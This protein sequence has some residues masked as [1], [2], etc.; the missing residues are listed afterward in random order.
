MVRQVNSYIDWK[1]NTLQWR[2]GTR[3]IT[4]K[5]VQDPQ[6]PIMASSMFEQG[7]SVEQISAQRMR[8]IAK[9]ETILLAVVR[10][11]NDNDE[12]QMN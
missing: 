5:G 1:Q 2:V 6:D 8:K 7:N 9:R 10:T 11:M 4:I 12:E 3:L